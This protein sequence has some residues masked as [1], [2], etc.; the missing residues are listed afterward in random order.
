LGDDEPARST[1][2]ASLTLSFAFGPEPVVLQLS[3]TYLPIYQQFGAQ[4]TLAS[5]HAFAVVTATPVVTHDAPGPYDYGSPKSTRSSISHA[6]GIYEESPPLPGRSRESSREE[7]LRGPQEW[8][9]AHTD[10]EIDGIGDLTPGRPLYLFRDGSVVYG[11]LPDGSEAGKASDVVALL[12]STDWSATPV[13]ARETWSH[14]LLNAVTIAMEYPLPAAVWWGK[15]LTF[16]YNQ[17]YADQMFDHPRSFGKSGPSSWA[18]EFLVVGIADPRTVAITGSTQR[19]GTEGHA[20][21]EG[22]RCGYS[23][24]EC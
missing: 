11:P 8:D 18:G 14:G 24:L 3:K 23:W 16:I 15:E 21:V 4:R 22:G 20:G 13:G 19:F 12:E 2:K 1:P 5:A 6:S 17:M 10:E 7:E 9:D